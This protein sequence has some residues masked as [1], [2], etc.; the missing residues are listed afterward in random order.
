V[1]RVTWTCARGGVPDSDWGSMGSSHREGARKRGSW[2]EGELE[3]GVTGHR[4]G[5]HDLQTRERDM[6]PSRF[7][8]N[9]RTRERL[10][11]VGVAE[12]WH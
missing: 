2:R 1:G 11:R 3:R 6:W 5:V 8:K 10:E 4:H 12:I 7:A 9:M